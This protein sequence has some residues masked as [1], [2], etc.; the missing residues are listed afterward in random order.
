MSVGV[1]LQFDVSLA[2]AGV[3]AGRSLASETS[4]ARRNTFY[5][6]NHHGM[7]SWVYHAIVQS[8]CKNHNDEKEHENH[9][10]LSFVFFVLFVFQSLST[11]ALSDSESLVDLQVILEVEV[12]IVAD[13]YDHTI[14]DD[15]TA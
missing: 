6:Q 12:A 13:R 10:E 4:F 9:Q 14:G 2:A 15:A 11:L 7:P 8:I 3:N 1:G 5:V